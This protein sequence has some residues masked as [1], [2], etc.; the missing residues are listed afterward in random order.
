MAKPR[1]HAANEPEPKVHELKRGELK[2]LQDRRDLLDEIFQEFE[3]E[4]GEGEPESGRMAAIDELF[5]WWVEADPEERFPEEMMAEV[6]G[7]VLGDRLARELKLRWVIIEVAGDNAIG[8]ADAKNDV[9]LHPL[10]SIANRLNQAAPG[11]VQE[12]FDGLRK[13][14]EEHRRSA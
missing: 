3:I 6:A 12:I 9:L 11:M 7:V 13:A 1:T 2:W 8:L 10:H 14:C 5:G 4:P